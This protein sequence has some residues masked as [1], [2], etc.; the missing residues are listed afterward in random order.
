MIPST[1]LRLNTMMRAMSES[2]LPALDPTDSLAQE[3]AGLLM[4]HINALIQQQG[5]EAEIDQQEYH[6]LSELAH[7]LLSIADGGEQTQAAMSEV[8]KAI[9]NAC[10]ISLSIATEK[11]IIADD[12]SAAFK[13]AARQPILDYARLSTN[14]GQE[15]FKPMGF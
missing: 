14:R 1:E 10:R 5:K 7:Q 13:A 9:K 11:L 4:G 6:D 8:S 15:W 12:A 2:I 3:Q